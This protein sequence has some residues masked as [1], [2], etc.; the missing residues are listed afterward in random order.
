MLAVTAACLPLYIVRWRVGPLPTTLLENLILLTI[1]AY[2]AVLWTEKRLPRARTPYDIPIALLL[3]AGVVGIFVA[4]D[5]VRALGIYRAYFLEAIAVFY[6]AVDLLRSR[7]DLR[8][9]LS[10]AGVGA[11]VFA[12]GQIISFVWV[13]AHNDLHLGAAPSFLNTSAN[14]DAMYLEPLLAFAVAFTLFPSRPGE[15]ILAA[16]VLALLFVAMITALSRASF[17]AMGVLAVVLAL[18]AQTPRWRLRAVAAFAVLALASLEIPFVLDRFLTLARSVANRES[19]YRQTLEMLSHMPITGAGIAGF[20]T[21]VA[22]YRPTDQEVQIYPHDIWLSMWSE[23]GLVG[24]LAFAV[25]F[26][27]ILWR[28]ARALRTARDIARPLL[29]G[30]VCGIVLYSVHGLFDTPY[31]KNDLSVLFW[32]MAALQVVAGRMVREGERAVR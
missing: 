27:A 8:V 13:V 4:P 10:V 15:R 6:I 1:A 7:D 26:F 9:F 17:L 25:I 11:A 3:L 23:L 14:A 28:S 18:T 19:I 16:P 5:H 22:P 30:C 29:W 32:L 2:A 21:R 24:L 31:W 12:I 20:A